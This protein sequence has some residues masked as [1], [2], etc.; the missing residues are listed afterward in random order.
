MITGHSSEKQGYG[1]KQVCK[2]L[3]CDPDLT[4]QDATRAEAATRQYHIPHPNYS[5]LVLSGGLKHILRSFL[6]EVAALP[7][8]ILS[9]RNHGKAESC[10]SQGPVQF[11]KLT[12]LP[13]PGHM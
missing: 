1:L 9:S 12:S 10:C 7:L 8:Y 4:R 13:W 5:L 3:T 6:L 11:C 2:E